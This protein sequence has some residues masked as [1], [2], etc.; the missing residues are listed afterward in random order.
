MVCGK[1]YASILF[2]L[3]PYAF[4]SHPL[5]FRTRYK[6][7]LTL[8]G[9]SRSSHGK[10]TVTD[11]STAFT[12]KLLGP[13]KAVR[14]VLIMLKS[15][16]KTFLGVLALIFWL[17]L[18]SQTI[19]CNLSSSWSDCDLCYEEMNLNTSKRYFPWQWADHEVTVSWPSAY[20]VCQSS[21]ALK[22]LYANS[23][24]S[25]ESHDFSV[26]Y[27]IVPPTFYSFWHKQ[28][29]IR[30]F[31]YTSENSDMSLFCRLKKNLTLFFRHS[32]WVVDIWYQE[33]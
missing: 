6:D 4:I 25:T 13:L 27:C 10:V 1:Y 30:V 22:L 26:K 23:A 18:L 17:N 8:E 21:L 28:L 2:E 16:I 15:S 3:G 29:A 9:R 33:I 32:G 5:S 31:M 24:V 12:P 14:L 19:R 7:G 11:L 20:A